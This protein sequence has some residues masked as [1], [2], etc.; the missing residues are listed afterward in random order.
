MSGADSRKK[1]IAR[2]LGLTPAEAVW[3]PCAC[4]LER[5]LGG[6]PSVHLPFCNVSL[7]KVKDYLMLG[8]IFDHTTGFHTGPQDRGVKARVILTESYLAREVAAGVLPLLAVAL[9]PE[10]WDVYLGREDSGLGVWNPGRCTSV[11][12]VS[13]LK[14]SQCTTKGIIELGGR[15]MYPVKA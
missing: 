1:A 12:F 6:M 2:R 14:A 3:A 13:P 7:S 4:G 15:D 8:S 10:G 9:R 11:M 5:K